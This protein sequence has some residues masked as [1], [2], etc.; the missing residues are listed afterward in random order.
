MPPTSLSS[1][2]TASCDQGPHSDVTQP[3]TAV[4]RNRFTLVWVLLGFGILVLFFGVFFSPQ[5]QGRWEGIALFSETS[6]PAARG[7]REKASAPVSTLLEHW[8]EEQTS[9]INF[10]WSL[11]SSRIFPS[12][13]PQTL[14]PSN[15]TSYGEN[16]EKGLR[17][18][19]H[20]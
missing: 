11:D 16:T 20:N 10:C 8:R 19:S 3:S 17:Q 18:V 9:S 2:K 13:S 12:S 4:L 1:H 6:Q 7:S 15:C 14:G 5:R